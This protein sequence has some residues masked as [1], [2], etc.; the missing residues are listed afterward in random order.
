LFFMAALIGCESTQR[1]DRATLD[2]RYQ[3]TQLAEGV[4]SVVP[5]RLQRDTLPPVVVN[6]WYAGTRDRE[7]RIV[8]REL[9]WDSERK[10]TGLE[11]RYRIAA[12]ELAIAEPFASTNDEARWL[13]LYEAAGK[14]IEPPA[15]LP[16][17]R[18]APNPVENDPIQRPEAPP[19]PPT[20]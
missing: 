2:Q 20:D 10:P 1:I 12:S 9:T 17:A 16:T 15:D 14:E 19:Q 3:E 11:R 5:A 8:C 18:K 4:L 6:W 7:H 13:P